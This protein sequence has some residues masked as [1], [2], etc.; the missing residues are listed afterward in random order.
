MP[1]ALLLMAVGYA[2]TLASFASTW[3]EA[4]THGYVVL[5]LCGWMTV[6]DRHRYVR[7][8]PVAWPVTL[9]AVVVSMGWLVAAI[10]EIRVVQQFALPVL[11]V[12]W[13]T[14]LFGERGLRLALPT[15]LVFLMAVPFWEVLVGPLQWFT[16]QANSALIS[17]FDLGARVDGQRIHFPFGIIEVAES[18]A[19]LSYFM[20]ALTI[21]VAYSR[22]FLRS[23]EG[24]LV[25][26]AVALL[27]AIVSNWI[28][29]FGLVL[30]GYQ[31]QMRSSLMSEHATYGWVIFAIVISVFFVFTAKIERWE[32]HRVS[33]L[34]LWAHDVRARPVASSVPVPARV[35]WQG[36]AAVLVGPLLY[37]GVAA[38]PSRGEM[39]TGLPGL[40]TSGWTQTAA[41]VRGNDSGASRAQPV[42]A[43]ASDSE[44]GTW[45]PKYSGFTGARQQHFARNG[46]QLQV[47]HIVFL[48][49]RQGA[50]LV[51]GGN[52]IAEEVLRDRLVGPLDVNLRVVREAI[53]RTPGGARVVWY[54]YRVAGI[55]TAS[56]A[57]V[58]LLELL[59]FLSRR[60]ES[61]LMAVSAP[62]GQ[63]S[64]EQATKDIFLLVTGREWSTPGSTRESPQ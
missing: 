1:L 10:V 6:V 22:L 15:G 56:P 2:S 9:L 23:G 37:H 8:A 36:T 14:V 31:T 57:R 29:V 51:G 19:G 13:L 61:E 44:G 24:T 20:S 5:A 43:A 47:D 59:A 64:C 60:T 63:L 55:E 33:R 12:L 34:D 17:L 54:W 4:R 25:A 53:V 26:V 11:L 32:A 45:I 7:S 28:R 27:L 16:V 52:R 40:V 3:N 62:C 39:G 50:E 18:C 42:A 41:R 58:K 38:L 21:A 49:Q 46:R 48:A 35:L 30:I